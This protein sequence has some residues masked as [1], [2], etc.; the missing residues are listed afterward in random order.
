MRKNTSTN[1]QNEQLLLESCAMAYT[2]SAL[3]GRWKATILW[4]LLESPKR[5]KD[6][7]ELVP[8]IT[9]RMLSLSLKEMVSDGLVLKM[10]ESSFPPQVQYQ[11]TEKGRTLEGLLRAMTDWGKAHSP[12][13]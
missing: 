3:G 1:F 6:L 9:Q 8:N 11:L 12:N 4:N 5:Y 2:L 10:K 13:L 7:L